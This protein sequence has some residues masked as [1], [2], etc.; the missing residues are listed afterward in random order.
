MDKTQKEV[1]KLKVKEGL[2]RTLV[3][4]MLTI[5]AGEGTLIFKM[6]SSKPWSLEFKIELALFIVLFLMSL[7]VGGSILKVWFSI[8]KKIKEL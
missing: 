2:L 7:V 5:G 1:E 4:S 6:L 8:I 3:I